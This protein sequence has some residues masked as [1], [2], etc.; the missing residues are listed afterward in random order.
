MRVIRDEQ[1]ARILVEVGDERYAHIREI[2]DA[3]VG[4]RVL[5]AIADL[6]RFTGGMAA[7]AQAVRSAAQ[8]SAQ[9]QG[10]SVSQDAEGQQTGEAVDVAHAPARPKVPAPSTPARPEP[11][12]GAPHSI[13]AFFQRGLQASTVSPALPGPTSFVLEIEDILQEMVVQRTPPLSEEVHVST[14][15]QNQL[16][17]EVGGEV[18]GSVSEVPDPEIRTLI[19]AAV[20]EWEDR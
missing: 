10:L 6:I 8:Q 15:P 14:G 17:V 9:E 20:A 12:I 4:R 2:S 13:S 16:R 1:T 3:Q 19:Q 11:D 18:Y 7:N 5:W